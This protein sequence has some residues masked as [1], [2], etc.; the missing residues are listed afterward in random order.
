V[1]AVSRGQRTASYLEQLPNRGWGVLRAPGVAMLLL[2]AAGLIKVQL[3][4]IDEVYQA[5]LTGSGRAYLR[6]VRRD[7]P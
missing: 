2:H 5:R 7:L 1:P 6:E 4:P 3:S